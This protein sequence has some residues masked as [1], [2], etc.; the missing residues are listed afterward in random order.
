M[1]KDSVYFSMH[2]KHIRS[3]KFR[4]DIICKPA[5]TRTQHKAYEYQS[6]NTSSQVGSGARSHHHHTATGYK[7][8]AAPTLHIFLH[9][10]DWDT[11]KLF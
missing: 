6:Q 9:V 7:Q 10:K 2:I 5:N 3:E 11:E 8:K 4:D 1:K